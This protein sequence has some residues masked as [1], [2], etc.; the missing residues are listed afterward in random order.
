M[1]ELSTEATAFLIGLA[2]NAYHDCAKPIGP[3]S[4]DSSNEDG[5]IL[6]WEAVRNILSVLPS[7]TVHPWSEP[8]TFKVIQI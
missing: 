6:T 1:T 2:R 4:S 5:D 8:S 7:D 3:E